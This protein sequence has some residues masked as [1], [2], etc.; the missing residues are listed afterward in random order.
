MFC[1]SYYGFV[2]LWIRCNICTHLYPQVYESYFHL[3]P[4]K[5]L[6]YQKKMIRSSSERFKIS[7]KRNT[8]LS[9][10]VG[11]LPFSISDKYERP[12]FT[13]SDSLLNDKFLCFLFCFRN[14][15]NFN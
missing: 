6:Q 2:F 5:E 8:D 10:G 3:V 11:F 13:N 7:A 12:K 1:F 15:P 9:F 4:L 14:S